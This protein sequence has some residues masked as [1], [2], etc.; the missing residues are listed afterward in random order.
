MPY[1][2]S[3]VI[4]EKSIDLILD[5]IGIGNSEFRKDI[6]SNVKKSYGRHTNYVKKTDEYTEMDKL[7]NEQLKEKFRS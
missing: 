4:D 6:K 2:F 3:D 7:L 1:K 5:N